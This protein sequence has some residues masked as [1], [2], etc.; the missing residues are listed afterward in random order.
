MGDHLLGDG[1]VTLESPA[2][3][4]ELFLAGGPVLQFCPELFDQQLL[5]FVLLAVLSL[6]FS[7]QLVLVVLYL[8]ASGLFM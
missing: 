6:L 7:V 4:R 3:G 8:L 2:F 1:Q 5:F